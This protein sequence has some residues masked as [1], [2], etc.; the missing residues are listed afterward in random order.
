MVRD[1]L[2]PLGHGDVELLEQLICGPSGVALRRVDSNVI[3]HEH[4]A[5]DLC[6]SQPQNERSDL[7]QRAATRL[8]KVGLPV[9]V[10]DRQ[11]QLRI[12]VLVARTARSS[13][14]GASRAVKA[15]KV[16][17]RTFPKL[18]LDRHAILVAPLAMCTHI[19]HLANR[20][21]VHDPCA[22]C[23][24]GTALEVGGQL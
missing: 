10:I 19:L 23:P 16:P 14:R 24:A 13:E 18:V 6:Q 4:K 11:W 3:M 20:S 9:L 7:W 2:N 15:D 22:T 8:A 1:G 5:R 21:R 17:I 12:G